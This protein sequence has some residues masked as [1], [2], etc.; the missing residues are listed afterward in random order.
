MVK[1]HLMCYLTA[2]VLTAAE[3]LLLVAAVVLAIAVMFELHLNKPQLVFVNHSTVLN[4]Y[5]NRLILLPIIS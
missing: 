4:V 1:N 5:F 3:N 2:L